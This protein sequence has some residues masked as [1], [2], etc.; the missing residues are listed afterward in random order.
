MAEYGKGLDSIDKTF[1]LRNPG[2]YAYQ[3]QIDGASNWIKNIE[4]GEKQE[5]LVLLPAIFKDIDTYRQK[6]KQ[7]ETRIE[8]D[9]QPSEKNPSPTLTEIQQKYLKYY[10]V[11]IQFWPLFGI[12]LYK[13]NHYY[14]IRSNIFRKREE[15]H[16]LI[17]KLALDPTLPPE[18]II[19]CIN[20]FITNKQIKEKFNAKRNQKQIERKQQLLIRIQ[21][22]HEYRI[23]KIIQKEAIKNSK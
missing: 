5:V 10:K 12:I 2:Y 16:D 15:Y 23:K 1:E 9:H 17:Q 22:E 4:P 21:K 14:Q 19:L 18:S 8:Q 7:Y 13:Y 20:E 6:Q 3:D 11:P